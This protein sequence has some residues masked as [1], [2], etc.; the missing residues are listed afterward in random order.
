MLH[1]WSALQINYNSEQ[2]TADGAPPVVAMAPWQ[3]ALS[4]AVDSEPCDA[5]G[6]APFWE[7]D[8]PFAPTAASEF[9]PKASDTFNTSRIV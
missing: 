2:G 1:W 4:Q 8:V 3:I 7:T 9:I 6:E 5:E